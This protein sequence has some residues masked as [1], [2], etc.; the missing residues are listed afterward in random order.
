MVFIKQFSALRVKD[1]LCSTA[2]IIM[3]HTVEYLV[4]P[5]NPLSPHDASKHHFTSLKTD[6][7]FPH[8]RV[9]E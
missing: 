3:K 4:S 7:N 8:S 2:T 9:L 5:V 6:L 1:N